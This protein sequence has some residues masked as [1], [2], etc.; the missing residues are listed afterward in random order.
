MFGNMVITDGL[1]VS[2]LCCK[3][4]RPPA[5]LNTKVPLEIFALD[6]AK[7]DYKPNYLDPG[8]NH[9]F[10]AV[11]GFEDEKLEFK[12]LSYF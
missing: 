2:F 4:K 6:E 3:P 12:H 10:T 9:V 8:R 1:F 7:K 5:D 11:S